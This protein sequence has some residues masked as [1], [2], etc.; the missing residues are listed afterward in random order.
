VKI[1]HVYKAYYPASLGGVEKFIDSVA[2]ATTPLGAVHELLTIHQ[3]PQPKSCL[4]GAVMV[5]AFPQTFSL[6]S[7]PVSFSLFRRFKEM[8]QGADIIHYHFP[9]PFADFMH[10]ALGI[11]KPSIVTYHSDIVKQRLLKI[12][13]EPVMNCF[14]KKVNVIV[15]TSDNYLK[16]SPV[17]RRFHEKCRVIPLGLDDQY[18]LQ[19]DADKKESWKKQLGSNFALFVGV[20]R[21]YKGLHILLEALKDTEMS[22][23]IAGAGPEEAALKKQAEA[24]NLKN[25]FF[26]GFV[27]EEDKKALCSLCRFVVMPS[28]LRSEAFCLSLLEGLIYGKPLISTELNTGTTFVNQH[29]KT[30]LVVQPGNAEELRQAML[31]LFSDDVLCERFSKGARAHYDNYFSA[32]KMGAAY[33][34]IYQQCE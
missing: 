14:L 25:V 26:V 6:S 10:L 22:V 9:W 34:D 3:E 5:H 31:R 21:Y 24:L 11:N 19:V 1:I 30:G 13:Y 18:Y 28:H 29:D 16:T 7:C 23:V 27:N 12:P 4:Q 32:Q 15:P 8:T 2:L 33:Y 17:L 20:L